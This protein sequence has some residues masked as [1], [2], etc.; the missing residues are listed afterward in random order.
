MQT[1]RDFLKSAALLSGAL[2]FWGGLEESIARALTIAPD[3]GTSY[4][5]AENIVILMQENRSFDHCYGTLQGVRGY[6]DPRAITLPNNYPVWIQT[7]AAGESYAPFRLNLQDTKAT[8]M[9]YLPHYWSSQVDARNH[10]KYDQWLEAK[11][12]G[13]KAYANMPLT[14]GYY[15]RQD[16]PFYY[17]FADAFTI[18]DQH[19]CASITPTLPN[20]LFFWTGTVRE[21]PSVDSPA[22]VRNEQIMY[23]H[24]PPGW[25]TFPERLE[26]HGV[27][28]KIYQNELTVESG[29]DEEQDAWLGNFGCNVTEYFSQYNVNFAKGHRDYLDRQVNAVVAEINAV[30]S[31][32]A[33]KTL[34]A[35]QSTQYQQQLAA[36]TNS[37]KLAQLERDKYSLEK[38]N[39]LSAREQS[40]HQKAFCTNAGDPNYRQLDKLTYQDGNVKRGMQAPKGD[41]FYQFRQDVKNGN[42]PTVS[43]LVAPER[44]SDHP[45]SA[46]YG[47]WYISEALSILTEN[48]EV[49][50]KTIFILTYD[51]ND[52]YFDHVPPFVAPNP[53]QRQTG[54][55][56]KE[57]DASL[58]YIQLEQDEKLKM[59]DPRES[60]IGLGYR[61]PMVIASP[62]SRG[63]CVC[64]QVLDNTSVLRFLEKFL[65]FKTGRPIRE[66]NISSW[67]RAICGD[68]TSVFQASTDEKQTNPAFITRDPFVEQIY[69]TQFN[70]LPSGYKVLSKQDVQQIIKN[71]RSSKV[72]PQQ[73]PG[74]R[75]SCPLPYELYVNASLNADQSSFT[76]RMEAAKNQFAEQ[77][78]GCP[79]TVYARIGGN[80]MTVRNYAVA[81]GGYLEDSW[82][83]SDFANGIYH[84][85][86]YGP[87]GFFREFIGTGADPLL[88]IHVG[89]SQ[90]NAVN[91]VLDG[92]V[93]VQAINS[94]ASRGFTIEITDL[95]YKTGVQ[96]W[97]I[98][99]GGNGTFVINTQPGSR[100]YDLGLKVEQ[101]E[102]FQRRFA[103]RVETGQWGITDPA[104]GGVV[105]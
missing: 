105:G 10:G 60:P 19:F 5:D 66:T 72:M 42:L 47:A 52:G 94:D 87:N 64:S 93:Q 57:I 68:L 49:W 22:N 61:V 15:N 8:W 39:N 2:G 34:T 24:W 81:A 50:K 11:R 45:E 89:Y 53:L 83:I 38:F 70:P 4:L 76:I 98:G 44:L 82:A 43:W 63:G 13:H 14:L 65:T 40:L 59:R 28:W 16:I 90:T 9:G 3:P 79:F 12:S 21:K 6:N 41:V 20:R 71:P 104:M 55:T 48:P 7:N 101:I 62:W 25:T 99:P 102:N 67:R 69:K 75:P 78:V 96:K 80:D 86:V 51:E 95:S 17:A 29:L 37:L 46:W 91:P 31:Q 18:C 27:S 85:Q 36:L 100:W 58:E 92:N 77:S 74:V 23:N 26:D 35:Q 33:G 1:R 32:Y 30:K 88:E 97:S 103:G 56:S 54:F 73:E 84:L